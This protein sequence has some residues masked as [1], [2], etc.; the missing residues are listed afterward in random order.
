MNIASLIKEKVIL[1]REDETR[2]QS[3][4]DML[5]GVRAYYYQNAD[6]FESFEV[7]Y[8]LFLEEWRRQ[9]EVERI[10]EWQRHMES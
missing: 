4:P 7:Y 9:V 6:M 5:W 8:D 10:E 2:G 1:I 3:C